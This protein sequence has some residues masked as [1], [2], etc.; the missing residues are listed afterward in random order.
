MYLVNKC[1]PA[2]KVSYLYM[3]MCHSRNSDPGE[4]SILLEFIYLFG[5]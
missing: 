2:I 3:Y 4:S 1:I 5:K